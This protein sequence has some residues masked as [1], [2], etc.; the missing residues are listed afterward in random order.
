MGFSGRAIDVLASF[1]DVVARPVDRAELLES[2]PGVDALI[3]RLRFDVDVEV[4]DA[5]PGLK[6]VA[7]PTTGLDHIDLDAAEARGVRVI[8]LRGERAFLD[9]IPATAEHT[10]ALLLALA[11]RIPWASASVIAGE[12]D[13]DRFRGRELHG[14]R[15]GILG[16]GRVGSQ[17]AQLA[18]AFGMKVGAYDPRVT[19]WP[20]G[21]ERDS[22][23][24]S[25]LR[26]SDVVS[27]HVPLDDSTTGMFGAAEF[28]TMKPTAMLVNTSRGDVIDER[29][30]LDALESGAIAGAALD[31]VSGERSEIP[32]CSLAAY[33][34]SHDNLLV[35]PH[36]AGATYESMERCEIL[37]AER[38]AEFFGGRS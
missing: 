6:V 26:A 34:S 4:L 21:V 19:E 22:D 11:R 27:I 14:K 30:L 13:R 5:G 15:L 17:V 10:W 2:M 28:A 29:A 18:R 25:L 38:L 3:V 35:T 31:V 12:W 36:I 23:L 8:S 9:R 37:I 20:V 1:G 7:T 24:D 32:A 16:V 33:A